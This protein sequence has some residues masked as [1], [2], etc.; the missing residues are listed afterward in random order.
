MSNVYLLIKSDGN[1]SRIEIPYDSFNDSV[2]EI[3]KCTWYELVHLPG[4]FYLIVDELGKL[5][6]TP[7]PINVKASMLYPG[8]PHGD[9]IVGDVI[10]GKLG[11]VD[12]EADILGL[13]EDE[14]ASFERY[15]ETIALICAGRTGENKKTKKEM[16]K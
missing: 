4:D 12:G 13:T 10:F 1:V 7:L 3:I 11:Y 2:H 9:P 6:T 8:T 14:L 16:S 5:Y 15:F